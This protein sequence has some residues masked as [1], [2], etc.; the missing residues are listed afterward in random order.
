MPGRAQNKKP[1]KVWKWKTVV[2]SLQCRLQEWQLFLQSDSWYFT[3][4]HHCLERKPRF[5]EGPQRNPAGELKSHSWETQHPWE[6]K[7][8]ALGW[9]IVGEKKEISY[10]VHVHYLL[11]WGFHYRRRSASIHLPN[12]VILQESRCLTDIQISWVEILLQ[13]LNEVRYCLLDISIPEKWVNFQKRWHW[14]CIKFSCIDLSSWKLKKKIE[15][16]EGYLFL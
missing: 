4:C 2:L 14:T 5:Y 6:G 7:Q 8:A 9:L 1:R 15:N 11:W 12:K 16:L 13:G 10:H 3:K